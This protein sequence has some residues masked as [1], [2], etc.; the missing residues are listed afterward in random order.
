MRQADNEKNIT[1]KL[2]FFIVIEISVEP[3]SND[4]FCFLYSKLHKHSV[5]NTTRKWKRDYKQVRIVFM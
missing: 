1:N 3:Y 5:N 4:Q 2:S